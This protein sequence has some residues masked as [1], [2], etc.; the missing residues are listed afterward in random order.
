MSSER[1]SDFN[2]KQRTHLNIL[3]RELHSVASRWKEIGLFLGLDRNELNVVKADGDGVY[4]YLEGML[5]LWLK[6]TDPSPT[7]SKIISVLKALKLN[8]EAE[9]LEKKLTQS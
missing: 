5:S 9:S 3:Y 6:Q 2:L 8:D 1:S 4:S 7:K